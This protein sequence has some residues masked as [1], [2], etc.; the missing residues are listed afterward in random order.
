MHE[1]P[2]P[3]SPDRTPERELREP[4]RDELDRRSDPADPESVPGLAPVFTRGDGNGDGGVNIADASFLLNL[5]FGA[6]AGLPCRV[7]GDANADGS[8]NISDAS[9]L[10]NFLFVDG[11]TP[12]VPFP[13]C[14]PGESAGDEELGCETPPACAE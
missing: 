11:P 5:L 7:A 4:D 14:G 13:E 6:G 8:V 9:F 3:F 10:L 2:S 1:I 12:G